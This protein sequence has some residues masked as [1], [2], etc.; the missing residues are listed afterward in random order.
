MSCFFGMLAVVAM[1]M[2]TLIT[3]GLRH[4]KTSQYGVSN[5]IMG[6]QINAQIVI[7]GS[8]RALS[9]FDPRIVEAAT[10]LTAFNIG[11]NGSQTDMQLAVLRAYLEH[12]HKPEIVIHSLDSFSF[13]A[14]REVYDPAQYVPYLYDEALYGALRQ[15]N[16]SIW[17]SRYVPLYGYVVDDM[18]MSWISGLRALSGWSPREDF[19]LGF[20]PRPQKWSDEFESFKAA[21]PGGVK[22]PIDPEGRQSLEDLVRLCQEQG[23][24]L[25]FVY[26]PEYS[27]MQGL[28]KNRDEVFQDFHELSTRYNFPLWDYSDWKYGG[29]TVYFQNSQHLNEDGAEVFSTDLANHLKGYVAANSITASVLQGL[30]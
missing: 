27:E 9:D 5:K 22:W 17:K 13:E 30:R 6:G 19:Y 2:N 10:G 3:F 14:T 25:I 28:T 1:G 4:L 7:T 8:S 11:R 20:N 16:P 12:N 24:Q 26:P 29:D 23:I 21:N 15:I 18:S